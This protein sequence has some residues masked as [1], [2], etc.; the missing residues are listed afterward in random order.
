M[1]G[2]EYRTRNT[3]QGMMKWV[4]T[5]IFLFLYCLPAFLDVRATKELLCVDYLATRELL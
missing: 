1:K 2:E 3:E 4:Y 5:S